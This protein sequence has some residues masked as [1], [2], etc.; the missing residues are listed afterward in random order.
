MATDIKIELAG[1][2]SAVLQSIG[3]EAGL[4]SGKHQRCIYGCGNDNGGK[5]RARWVSDK[6]FYFCNVCGTCSPMD[7]AMEHLNKGFKETAE[8]LRQNSH[9]FTAKLPVLDEAKKAK[10]LVRIKNIYSGIKQV[11]RN[12]PVGLYLK[13][14]GLSVLPEQDCY[15]HPGLEY[16]EDAGELDI[17]GKK[18]FKSLGLFPCMVSVFRTCEGVVSTLHITYLNSDG[19]KANV[20][21][22]KKIMPAYR[23]LP[24][25][26]IRLFETGKDE[27]VLCIA[28]GIETSLAVRQ[29]TGHRVWASG[30][31]DQMAK[32][33]LTESV[34]TI[35]ICPDTDTNY[36]GLH[37]ATT[38][39]VRL[40]REGY[41]VH[42][43]QLCERRI[44][45]YYNHKEDYLD[46]LNIR[47]NERK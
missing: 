6:E 17:R 27:N 38:L 11:Q 8:R 42:L 21:A 39:A 19:T 2:W 10:N 16:W 23:P 15:F 7:M 47:L 3:I 44:V 14:R 12:D 13:N 28:E 35:V 37:A 1:K 46:Y 4:F 41:Q 9:N 29:L 31:A 22:V 18:V 36:C 45:N 43:V 32:L 40:I 24:G 30:N 25:S 5:D 26:A 20:S 33:Q 34:D